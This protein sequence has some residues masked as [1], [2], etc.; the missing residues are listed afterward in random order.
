MGVASSKPIAAAFAPQERALLAALKQAQSPYTGSL[1][2][3]K[4]CRQLGAPPPTP[5]VVQCGL[6]VKQGVQ[7]V[8][9]LPKADAGP[10]VWVWHMSS[11]HATQ[12]LHYQ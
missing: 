12:A 5:Q 11:P 7:K 4:Q 8:W 3:L 2:A 10:A 1:A 9:A 6:T